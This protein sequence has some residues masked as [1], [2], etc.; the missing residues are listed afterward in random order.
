VIRELVARRPRV[1]ES[2][3]HLARLTAR[4]R[5]VVALVAEGLTSDEIAHR[6]F[7]SPATVRTHTSR[8][9]T[10]L[11]VHD[12]AQLVVFAYQTGLAPDH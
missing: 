3:D 2:R 5:Q 8:A 10:K 1:T 11:H 9:M 12:R 7:L 4:E 6:L